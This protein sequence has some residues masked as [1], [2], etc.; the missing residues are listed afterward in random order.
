[1]LLHL[2]VEILGERLIWLNLYEV[3]FIM[4]SAQTIISEILENI[5]LLLHQRVGTFRLAF[6]LFEFIRV[7][8][9][10]VSTQIIASEI[11]ENMLLHLRVETL[12]ERLICLNLYEIFFYNG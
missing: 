10:N 8:V 4:F 5:L 12:G 1:M 3:L 2:R 6:S 11:L 7:I 9:Y